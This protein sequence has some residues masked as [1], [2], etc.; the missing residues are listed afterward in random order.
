MRVENAKFERI[1]LHD[2]GR[3]REGS[4]NQVYSGMHRFLRC[5]RRERSPVI[6]SFSGDHLLRKEVQHSPMLF[7]KYVFDE[8]PTHNEE[9]SE[10]SGF[11]GVELELVQHSS[12]KEFSTLHIPTL[13][14]EEAVDR[15]VPHFQSR[16]SF[17][18]SEE[19]PALQAGIG[20]PI[21]NISTPPDEEAAGLIDPI[22]LRQIISDYS[23]SMTFPPVEKDEA[24]EPT[25]AESLVDNESVSQT[26]EAVAEAEVFVLESLASSSEVSIH[27]SNN[28]I[29]QEE[30]EEILTKS[31]TIDIPALPDPEHNTPSVPPLPLSSTSSHTFASSAGLVE[32][33]LTRKSF[34][35]PSPMM[36]D[37]FRVTPQMLGFAVPSFL[38]PLSPPREYNPNPLTKVEEATPAIPL[39]WSERRSSVPASNIAHESS[40]PS[41]FEGETQ[42]PPITSAFA[43]VRHNKHDEIERLVTDFPSLLNAT[44][45]NN[46]ENTLLHVACSFGYARIVKRLI[47]FGANVDAT[48]NEGNSPLHVCYQ[49]GRNAIVSILIAAHANEN[50]RNNKDRVP[51]QLLSGSF[52]SSLET[53]PSKN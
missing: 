26:K 36:F 2:P 32:P 1:S 44:D 19:G 37:P 10:D 53:S 12:S 41:H 45:P 50:A 42:G 22:I 23:D 34:F 4:K 51:A 25:R 38:P 35:V 17:D 52:P 30:M 40:T 31:L 48:N 28:I 16:R 46:K 24:T 6:I 29:I 15:E 39:R 49:Y 5:L 47:K 14:A 27:L 18:F 9:P 43:A 13:I 8:G 7:P 3:T 11:S 20:I 33:S 21:F